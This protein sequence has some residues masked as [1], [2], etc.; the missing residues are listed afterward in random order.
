MLLLLVMVAVDDVGCV[1]LQQ[2][3]VVKYRGRKSTGKFTFLGIGRIDGG[4]RKLVCG[5]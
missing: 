3:S 1:L 5:E 2:Q 4:K